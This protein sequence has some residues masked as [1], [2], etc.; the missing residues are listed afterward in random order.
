M[1]P[2]VFQIEGFLL[3]LAAEAW[4]KGLDLKPSGLEVLAVGVSDLTTSD[5]S[6]QGLGCLRLRGMQSIGK[7]FVQRPVMKLYPDAVR[8]LAVFHELI[9]KCCE[10]L[11]CKGLPWYICVYSPLSLFFFVLFFL[12][13][14]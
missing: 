4:I 11:N 2:V 3:F 8:P 10:K 14:F 6:I 9:S 1:A 7:E 13:V 5:C 12:L